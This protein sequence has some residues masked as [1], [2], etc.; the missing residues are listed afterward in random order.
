M[1]P[2]GEEFRARHF[3]LTFFHCSLEENIDTC[4]DGFVCDPAF[5]NPG[6][7]FAHPNN[8]LSAAFMVLQAI[9]GDG[10]GT[11]MWRAAEARPAASS[12][13]FLLLFVAGIVNLWL[14]SPCQM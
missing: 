8:V 6:F 4:P 7:G 3:G 13:G 11:N 10:V 9:S 2:V 12:V 1:P 5:G 14:V